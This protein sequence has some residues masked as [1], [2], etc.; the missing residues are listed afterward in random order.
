MSAVIIM[1]IDLVTKEMKI[2]KIN[3]EVKSTIFFKPSFTNLNKSKNGYF[4][5]YGILISV[6]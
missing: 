6:I 3:I 4:N 2:A 5:Q 1:T